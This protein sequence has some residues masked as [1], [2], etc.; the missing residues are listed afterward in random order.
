ML[1]FLGQYT[2]FRRGLQP[3]ILRMA[4]HLK[5]KISEPLHY[6]SEMHYCLDLLKLTISIGVKNVVSFLTRM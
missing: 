5:P 1:F 4:R 2:L 6:F 3:P